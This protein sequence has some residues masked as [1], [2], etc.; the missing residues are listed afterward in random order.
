MRP[1]RQGTLSDCKSV[2]TIEKDDTITIKTNELYGPFDGTE[3]SYH[4]STCSEFD[5]YKYIIR[6]DK[7]GSDNA[8]LTDDLRI[9]KT[10]KTRLPMKT[11]MT[12]NWKRPTENMFLNLK[13]NSMCTSFLQLYTRRLEK[14]VEQNSN[15]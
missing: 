6:S 14:K 10:R 1:G 15:T 3:T 12:L 5:A 7:G 13:T 8:M 2:E 9:A 11:K 4:T